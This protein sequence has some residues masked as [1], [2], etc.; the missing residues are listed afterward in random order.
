M[1]IKTSNKT[2]INTTTVASVT[3]T[4]AWFTAVRVATVNASTFETKAIDANLHVYSTALVGTSTTDSSSKPTDSSTVTVDGAITHGSYNATANY[5]GELYVANVDEDAIVSSYSSHGNLT[6]AQ[7]VTSAPTATS[8]STWWASS[9]TESGN[10][11]NI[12][13]G[14]AWKMTFSATHSADDT[15][16]LFVDY[17]SCTFSDSVEGGTTMPGLRIALMTDTIVRV[18]GGEIET[19]HVKGGT[20][21]DFGKFAN[22]V[23]NV[24]GNSSYTKASDKTD[25]SNNVGL[26]KA[27][28]VDS[29][30]TT[31]S[32][33]V[34]AVAWFEG[35]SENIVS[36]ND[37]LMSKVTASLSFYTRINQVTGA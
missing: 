10:S 22:G 23:Y 27:M 2:L 30:K 6:K 5:T 18:I 36:D 35:E 21:N 17:K 16:S 25:F 31:S 26:I 15:L 32:L 12:W 34:T 20:T 4:V 13:Y 8:H 7:E 29:S 24:A 14:V 33:E 3:G 1:T 28:T 11:K 9:Y 37:T 19:N